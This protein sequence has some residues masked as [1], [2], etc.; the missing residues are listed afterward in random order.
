MVPPTDDADDAN[1]AWISTRAKRARA[2]AFKYASTHRRCFF[3]VTDTADGASDENTWKD[4]GLH[5]NV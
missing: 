3:I 1:G 2:R 4:L 5:N